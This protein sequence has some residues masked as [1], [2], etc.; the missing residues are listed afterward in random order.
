MAR[1]TADRRFLGCAR[2]RLRALDPHRPPQSHL[3][4]NS[5]RFVPAHHRDLSGRIGS[6]HE[7]DH[8]AHV[9]T[10]LKTEKARVE[11]PTLLD[12]V[13]LDIRN[14]SLNLHGSM[15]KLFSCQ[16]PT[17]SRV[18]RSISCGLMRMAISRVL[19]ANCANQPQISCYQQ[20]VKISRLV[21]FRQKAN[22]HNINMAA[23]KHVSQEIELI[24]ATVKSCKI[25]S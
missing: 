14:D 18:Q 2:S 23:H 11:V 21:S 24:D 19:L 20:L 4:L 12:S 7:C 6:G 15:A 5:S 9:H 22:Q 3:R 8:P 13:R 16:A 1:Q 25:K 17:E 10:D